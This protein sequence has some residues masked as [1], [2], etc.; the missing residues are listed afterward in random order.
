MCEDSQEESLR[1]C[2][3]SLLDYECEFNKLLEL[4]SVTD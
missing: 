1:L 2:G 3:G 4:N